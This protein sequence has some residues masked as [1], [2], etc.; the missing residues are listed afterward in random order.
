MPFCSR[1]MGGFLAAS[2]WT[3]ASSFGKVDLA[4]AMLSKIKPPIAR[5]STPRLASCSSIMRAWTAA[6]EL[7]SWRLNW[8]I[9]SSF[10]MRCP[11]GVFLAGIIAKK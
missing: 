11:F 10:G 3:S 1:A 7:E 8:L 4:P 6:P 2:C 9:Q 5:I